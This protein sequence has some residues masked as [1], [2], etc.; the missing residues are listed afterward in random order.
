MRCLSVLWQRFGY[1]ASKHHSSA[2]FTFDVHGKKRR[3]KQKAEVEKEKNKIN[4]KEIN[5]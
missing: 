4:T 3:E 2:T 1:G 5:I